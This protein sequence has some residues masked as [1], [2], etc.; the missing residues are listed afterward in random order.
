MARPVCSFAPP[1][2]GEGELGI[3]RPV[4]GVSCR[5]WSA[6]LTATVVAVIYTPASRPD[7]SA[8]RRQPGG[9]VPL[10]ASARS[11]ERSMA[12]LVLKFGGTSVA[13]L[14]RIRASALHV[15]REIDAGHEVA[16]VVS[17]MAGKTNEL[18]AWCREASPL[19]DAREYDAIVASGEQVTAGLMAIVLQGM[20][21]TARSW[22]G[23]QVPILTSDQHGS[24][25]VGDMVRIRESRPLS[26]LKRWTLE[27]I[28][29]RSSLGSIA[30]EKPSR[31]AN[32]VQKA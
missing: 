16:V 28:I 5:V 32:A 31:E 14:E 1:R 23:W 21:I 29:R 2:R 9:R 12:R 26:K 4:F 3:C 8:G 25:R 10:R 18:V 15:K 27:E 11:N 30:D 7:A 17:A 24:A 6:A 22:Q 19:H 13:N 20:G